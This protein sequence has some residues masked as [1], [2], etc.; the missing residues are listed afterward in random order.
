VDFLGFVPEQEL[1]RLYGRALL[2]VIPS[3]CYE[4]MP[5]TVL[6]SY[7]CG[8]P[9]LGSGHG[10]I[11]SLIVEGRTGRCFRPGDPDDLAEKLLQIF[12]D[13]AWGAT[14]GRHARDHAER[15]FGVDRHLE[16]LLALMAAV[17][18]G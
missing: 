16:R 1:P 4:N 11:R 3:V 7:A 2:T 5:N 13:P 9:V 14:A 18:T 10:S 17:S 6:E 8:T 12:R 15:E